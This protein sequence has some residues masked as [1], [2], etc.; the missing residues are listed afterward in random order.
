LAASVSACA[1]GHYTPLA[2]AERD[3]VEQL[4][5]NVFRVEYEVN[6]F[7]SQER[8]DSYLKRRCAELTILQGYDYFHLG[9]RFDVLMLSRRTSITVTMF[10]GELTGPSPDFH[11]ARVVLGSY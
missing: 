3:Q 9:Q 8:L 1:T 10:R 6:P 2:E 7:T 11:D 5:E 4:K